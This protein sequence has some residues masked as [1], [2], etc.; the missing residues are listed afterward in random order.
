M[1][2]KRGIALLF[3]TVFLLADCGQVISLHTCLRSK[4]VSYSI[5][6]QGKECCSTD[7]D[8]NDHCIIKRTCCS[9][10]SKYIKQSIAGQVEVHQMP[11]NKQANTFLASG[12]FILPEII[13]YKLSHYHHYGPPTA[14]NTG[15][16]FT[17]VFRC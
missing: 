8:A 7:A 6:P 1:L 2:F 10:T 4:H 12:I 16:S 15:C 17:Q 11:V 3:L 13:V 9:V 14:R 5:M